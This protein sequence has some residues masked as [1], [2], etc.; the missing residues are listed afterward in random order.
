MSTLSDVI[1]EVMKELGNRAAM[2]HS[3]KIEAYA[4]QIV[5]MRDAQ[6]R[7]DEE[8]LIVP[9]SKN[10]PVAH[11]AFEIERKAQ[12]E[13]RKWGDTFKPTTNR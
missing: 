6:R 13:I 11:P 7:I 4:G 3:A 10:H 9:D 1:D 12:D 2:I 5:R 8:G